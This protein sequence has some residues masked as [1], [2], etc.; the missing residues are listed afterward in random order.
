MW[1]NIIKKAPTSGAFFCG[2][3]IA[4]VTQLLVGW[5]HLFPFY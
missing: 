5:P 1:L 4:T 2:L 3:G